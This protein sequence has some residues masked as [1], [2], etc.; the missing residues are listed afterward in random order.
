VSLRLFLPE[1]VARGKRIVIAS[2]LQGAWQSPTPSKQQKNGKLH[3]NLYR[4]KRFK[5]MRTNR[6]ENN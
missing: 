2:S 6:P 5:P 1:A 4:E 3:H